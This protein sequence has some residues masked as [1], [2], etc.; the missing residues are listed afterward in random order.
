ML[1]RVYLEVEYWNEYLTEDKVIFLFH[2][3]DGFKRYEVKDY[4]KSGLCAQIRAS[5]LAGGMP[6]W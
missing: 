4:H 5:S 6:V 3:Q 1:G 2:L